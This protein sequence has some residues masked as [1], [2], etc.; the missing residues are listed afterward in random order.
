[1]ATSWLNLLLL[2][3]LCFPPF[4]VKTTHAVL[5]RKQLGCRLETCAESYL[6]V[7][8][9][10]KCAALCSLSGQC[11][12]GSHVPATGQCCLSDRYTYQPGND[13]VQEAEAVYFQDEKDYAENGQ[14][15]MVFRAIS[16]N[17]QNVH[18]AFLNIGNYHDSPLG[19]AAPLTCWS[20][21]ASAPCPYHVRSK[22]LDLWKDE[23]ISPNKI[24]FALYK[25][26]TEVANIVF[27]GA[28]SN[29]TNWFNST[30]VISSSYTDISTDVPYPLFNFV[31]VDA[32]VNRTF[33][34]A[35]SHNGCPDDWGWV[36]VVER[37]LCDYERG[38]VP[39]FIYSQG[40][41]VTRWNVPGHAD[42]LAVFLDL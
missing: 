22:L 34:A 13:F 24:K 29:L 41:T 3:L 33:Y 28:K 1:M 10:S 38:V 23:T 7:F 8:S 4:A 21:S 9:V 16:S 20:I 42:V 19:G 31:Y 15:T 35:H 25:D 32:Y 27:D 36:S 37:F 39:L 12:S 11:V 30:R 5:Y 17:G 2:H 6:D 26:S 18:D 14:W 40:S